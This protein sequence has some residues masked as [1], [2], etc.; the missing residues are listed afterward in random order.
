MTKLCPQSAKERDACVLSPKGEA[1]LGAVE[2]ALKNGKAKELFQWVEQQINKKVLISPDLFA[3][4]EEEVLAEALA[5]LLFYADR[6]ASLSVDA[7]LVGHGEGNGAIAHEWFVGDYS[8]QQWM[9]MYELSSL[10]VIACEDGL[11]RTA[12]GFS[13]RVHI[14]S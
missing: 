3:P 13:G 9:E 14:R 6:F 7:I 2:S 10:H 1:L 11:E 4:R 12:G 5:G 8:V